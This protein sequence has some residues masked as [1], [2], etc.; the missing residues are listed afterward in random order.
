LLMFARPIANYF[1]K[2]LTDLPLT[3]ED[4]IE[5]ANDHDDDDDNNLA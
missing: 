2:N 1:A 5:E 3:M 4:A